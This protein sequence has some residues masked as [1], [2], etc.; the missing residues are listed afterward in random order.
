MASFIEGLGA[1]LPYFFW[2]SL[3]I[4]D[5]VVIR[6]LVFDN[7]QSIFVSGVEGHFGFSVF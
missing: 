6:A 1:E 3:D 5:K 7:G 2:G 4:D